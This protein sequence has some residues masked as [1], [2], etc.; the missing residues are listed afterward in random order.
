MQQSVKLFF[1]Y[2]KMSAEYCDGIA[3]RYEMPKEDLALRGV[4][5]EEG[6]PKLLF[7]VSKKVPTLTEQE[8]AMCIRVVHNDNERPE[9]YYCRFLPDHP[10]AAT[11]RQYKC[12]KPLYMRRTSMGEN[13]A[14]IDW[15]MK[16]L[17]IGVRTDEKKQK[18]FSWPETSNVDGLKS[19]EYFEFEPSKPGGIYMKCK[20]VPIF[21]DSNQLLF[22]GEPEMM[23]DCKQC[24]GYSKYI[25]DHFSSV[26]YFDEPL[27]LKMKE[28]IKL[29]LAVEW[30]KEK[31]V[32]FSQNWILEQTAPTHDPPKPLQVEL[33]PDQ[34]N[35]VMKS[36][37]K[38][39]KKALNSNIMQLFPSDQ[40]I[41]VKDPTVKVNSRGIE[42][43]FEQTIS[44]PFCEPF[45]T[46]MS[47]RTSTHDLDF[48][49]AGMD[50]NMPVTLDCH[51]NAL[52][53]PEVG[54]WSELM[55]ETEVFPCKWL[56]D[57]SDIMCRT[58]ALTGGV[59]TA[60]IPVKKRNAQPQ[61]TPIK[62]AATTSK[63]K[64]K[65]RHRDVPPQLVVNAPSSSAHASTPGTPVAT[66]GDG[67]LMRGFKAG[68]S[69]SGLS[70]K[71]VKITQSSL[72]THGKIT[73][74]RGSE[75]RHSM[76]VS[77]NIS[78]P[79]ESESVSGDSSQTST[80]LS[81]SPQPSAIA[82]PLPSVIGS[83]P[84]SVIGSPPSSTIASPPLFNSQESC[85]IALDKDD[86]SS[87]V[88]TDS[89]YT[90]T[91]STPLSSSPQ[92]SVIGSP[93][94]STIALPP[95]FNSQESCVIALDKDDSASTVSADSGLS[96]SATM[97]TVCYSD[98]DDTIGDDDA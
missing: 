44:I 88:S 81:S 37:K 57:P 38:E 25:T 32:N 28:Y 46:T 86:S 41:S 71:G 60:N 24:P 16:C 7:D 55:A 45:L 74:G 62:V 29:I 73:T 26:A 58:P 94:P 31:K 97:D 9:F 90:S 42:A 69:S 54:S 53:L 68:I 43:K 56:Q 1:I 19:C 87:T 84:P 98:S 30:L 23:I 72:Y 93:S 78:L 66:E 89:A 5:I 77:M 21:E 18:F 36:L 96:S 59:S 10:L 51:T 27:F 75:V 15:K 35:S 12:Y 61:K 14:E 34:R 3:F 83:P 13:L 91:C 49:Y 8:V 6:Q 82:T 80:P 70:K 4:C 48:V 67:V 40:N 63:K 20:S 65:I 47:I 52:V 50:P 2:S 64:Q 76:G 11:G 85:V 17:S 79:P 33:S 92:A 22:Q 95:L 39:A